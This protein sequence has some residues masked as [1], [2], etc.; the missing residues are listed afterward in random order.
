MDEKLAEIIIAVVDRLVDKE[1][2]SETVASITEFLVGEGYTVGE[3]NNAFMYLYHS[4]DERFFDEGKIMLGMSHKG[5]V[6]VLNDFERSLISPEAYGYILQLSQLGLLTDLQVE[7]VIERAIYY[8]S[9][10]VELNDLKQIV[11]SIILEGVPG[12]RPGL[13]SWGNGGMGGSAAH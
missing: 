2:S 8:C 13:I 3:I 7:E 4:I 9:D 11:P 10:K 6:R 1:A 12:F 5:T